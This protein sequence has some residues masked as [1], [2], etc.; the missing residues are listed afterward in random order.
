LR[1]LTGEASARVEWRVPGDLEA[2]LRTVLLAA[3]DS[4]KTDCG[5]AAPEAA[6]QTAPQP[7]RRPADAT[8]WQRAH[9]L[10]RPLPA[11]AAALLIMIGS[12]GGFVLGSLGDGSERDDPN[13]AAAT[14]LTPERAA[15][16]G[17]DGFS[18]L[19]A[20]AQV[21]R[22]AGALPNGM[23]TKRMLTKRFSVAP[24]DAIDIRSCMPA[25]SL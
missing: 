12:A 4:R 6:P 22:S 11:Y 18:P 13:H 25:D 1:A 3:S 19:M 20:D 7:A 8:R 17:A 5:H 16:G 23:P 9:L 2:R 15:A 24:S 10:I 14:P 21:P